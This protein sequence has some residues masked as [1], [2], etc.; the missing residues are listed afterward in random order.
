ME[1]FYPYLPAL[2]SLAA[3]A[4]LLVVLRGLLSNKRSRRSGRRHPS[5]GTVFHE[6]LHL[7]KLHDYHADLARKYG[8]FRVFHPPRNY[9][10]LVDPADVEYILRTNFTNYGK[11]TRTYASCDFTSRQQ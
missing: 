2:A 3:A 9:V 8:A 11:L 1:L 6:L 7:A 5:A 4:A 10:Y